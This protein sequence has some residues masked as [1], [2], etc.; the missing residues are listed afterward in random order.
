MKIC[1]L[2]AGQGIGGAERSMVRLMAQAHP[3]PLRCSVI[4]ANGDNPALREMLKPLSI[5]VRVVG[6]MQLRQ[7]QHIIRADKPDVVYMFGQIRPIPWAIAARRAGVRATV[8]AERGSGTRRINQIGRRL[9]KHWLQAYITNS[10]QTATVLHE[11]A[12]I[13]QD[14]LFVA[15]NG[16]E[17][18]IINVTAAHCLPE[19]GTPRIVCVANIRPLKGQA[20]LLQAVQRLRAQF[21]TLKAVLLGRDMTDGA[22]F[23]EMARRGLAD[24]FFWTGYVPDV[25]NYLATADI[26]A[27]PTVSR[28]GM[29]TSILEGMRAGL[30]V[31]GTR[32]G[33]VPE[34]IDHERTGL[35]VAPGDV[36]GLTQALQRL[37]NSAELRHQLG[38]AGRQ[39]IMQHHTMQSMIEQHLTA[40]EYALHHSI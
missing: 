13:P 9:D 35:L 36:D 7:L 2:F 28:E 6:P 31:I 21:P 19:M 23:E 37:L 15:Y 18:V 17:P 1:F 22:F 33:G 14:K 16:I 12:K 34:L 8:G 39:H 10:Q 20:L 38:E 27:L 11:Q 29:P 30:P 26:M 24:T 40:F 5:P 4:L 3:H 25:H 32:V